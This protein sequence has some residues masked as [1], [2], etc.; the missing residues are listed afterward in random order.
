MNKCF[1]E[2]P[3]RLNEGTEIEI[4]LPDEISPNYQLPDPLL[5]QIYEDRAHRVLWL[6]NS[7]SEET[8]Y[9]WVD[10][11]LRCNRAD[12]GIPVEE[13]KPIKLIIANY[14]GSLEMARTLISIIE[15]SK[16]P[17]YG[18]AIGPVCSA[19]SMI[20]LACQKKFALPTAY[21]MIHKG[22]CQQPN[23]DY[24]TLM[25]AMDDYKKQVEEL[26]QFYIGHT[27]FTEDEIRKNIEKDWYIYTKEAV[28]KGLCDVIVDDIDELL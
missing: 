3:T 4:Q 21:L 15:I 24:N 27:Q 20:F 1:A 23:A 7:V 26:I 2:N 18:Y 9:D 14:G 25:A 22:S 6:L 28:E 16:T 10:F 8:G 17:I 12:K 11:I 19:A 5:L 13:R